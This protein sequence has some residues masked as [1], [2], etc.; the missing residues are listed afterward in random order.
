MT[1]VRI[2][3]EAKKTEKRIAKLKAEGKTEEAAKLE[4]SRDDQAF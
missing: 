3:K 1:Q 2:E 4:K